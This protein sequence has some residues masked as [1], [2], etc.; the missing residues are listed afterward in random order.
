L[1]READIALRM[2]RPRQ[3]DLVTRH[4]LDIPMGVFAARTYLQ[5]RGTPRSMGDFEDHDIV[6]YDQVTLIRDA[7]AQLGVT[8]E[9]ED[10]PVRTDDQTAYWELVRAGAGIGFTQ[11]HV[12]RADPLV[13][14]LNLEFELPALPLWLTAH[15]AV[16]K[17][18]RVA[19]V[20]ELL[21]QGLSQN[22]RRA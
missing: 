13:E 12:G 5:R 4:V 7:M 20:W 6:G 21:D 15:E 22:L 17:T 11:S 8:A 10:F 14:E 9:I 1:F 3:L 18:P 2:Y 16:R 19:R